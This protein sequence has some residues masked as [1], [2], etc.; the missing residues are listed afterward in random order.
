M[1]L[2]IAQPREIGVTLVESEPG[3]PTACRMAIYSSFEE[4][5]LYDLH[6]GLRY[7]QG[8]LQEEPELLDLVSSVSGLEMVRYL[9]TSASD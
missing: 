9:T 6:L 5:E 2:G 3:A 7:L 1:H 4:L 8:I